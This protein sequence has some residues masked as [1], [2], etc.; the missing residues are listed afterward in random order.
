VDLLL[1]EATF[2]QDLIDEAREYGHS[3]ASQ[4][5]RV[6]SDAG[7]ARL[8]ITHISSRY[9]DATQLLDQ[10]RAANENTILADDL[11]EIEV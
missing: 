2:A 8:A 11:M 6:A 3:T 1:H 9:S 4:A 7:A 5:G 10:A